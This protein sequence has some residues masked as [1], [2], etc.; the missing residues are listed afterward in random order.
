MN[1]KS[2]SRFSKG[3]IPWNKGINMSEEQKEVMKQKVYDIRKGVSYEDIYGKEKAKNIKK[4]LRKSFTKERRKEISEKHLGIKLSKE[5]RNKISKSNIG[6]MVSHETRNKK[7]KKMLGKKHSLETKNKISNSKKGKKRGEESVRKMIKTMKHQ[8]KNGLRKKGMLGKKL[9]DKQK[10]A[11]S[12]KRKEEYRIGKRKPVR[13]HGE[14][15]PSWR[16]GISFEPYNKDFD[17]RFKNAIRTR[18]NQICM[19]CNIHREK[20]RRALNVHHINYDKLLS[21]KE[22]CICLCDSCHSRT[23]HNRKHWATFFQSLLNEKYK[24]EYSESSKII[25]NIDEVTLN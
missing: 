9:T 6:R 25:I 5:H 24:Y 17:N 22:N 13:M 10:Q 2:N 14:D 21:I 4:K 12:N 23:H 3:C 15:N 7:R 11:M 16:G 8:Y 20:L 18:D 1:K 19:L